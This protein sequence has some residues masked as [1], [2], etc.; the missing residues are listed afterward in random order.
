MLLAVGGQPV[1]SFRDVET[2]IAAEGNGADVG[3]PLPPPQQQQVAGKL[4]EDSS[5]SRPAKRQ[6]SVRQG[7][8]DGALASAATLAAAAAVAVAGGGTQDA[9]SP[10]DTEGDTGS[11]VSVMLT[12]FRSGAVQEV[13]LRLGVEDGMGTH[14]L[15]HWC[16]AQL[17]A[18]HRAVRELGFLPAGGAGVYIS[19]WHHGSPAHRY[20]LYALH[21][22]L[23]VNGVRTPD[24]D[25]FLSVVEQLQDG[26]FARL[27]VCHLE[28]TQHKVGRR[29]AVR[30]GS[31]W[32]CIGR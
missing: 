28:T 19:R 24:L 8:K 9:K 31:I 18:P 22:I 11:G 27:K 5:S 17:Q 26:D 1:S 23:E 14:R 3:K 10:A 20:G 4:G 12:V 6:R 29:E 7:L 16:G 25:T 2:L 13:E 32:F 30:A 15:L 21:W